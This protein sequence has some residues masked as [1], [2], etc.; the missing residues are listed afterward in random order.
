[1]YVLVQSG[2][3]A[4]DAIKEHL[5][6]YSYAPEKITDRDIN[7]TLVVDNFGIKYRHKKTWTTS[8]QPCKKN[9]R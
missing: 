8:Y 7:L 4:H 2:I 3:I 5:K 1:M 9:M 6:T